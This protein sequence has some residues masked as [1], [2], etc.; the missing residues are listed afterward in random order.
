MDK[1]TLA[2]P[3][4][5]D[6]GLE[7]EVR[8]LR[9][10]VS[11]LKADRLRRADLETDLNG[12]R[13]IYSALLDTTSSAVAVY[14]PVNDGEDFVF[15]DL[16][17][18]GE[19]I[20]R[21]SRD[22][23][24]DRRVTQVFPG[25]KDSGLFDVFQ[26]AWKSGKRQRFPLAAYRDE[27]DRTTWREGWVL[28][29]PAGRLIAVYD[30]VTERTRA[31]EA[32]QNT[33]D[34]YAN[35]LKGLSEAVYRMS[36]PDGRYE[37]FSPAC[38]DV[39]GYSARD[40]LTAPH[41]MTEIVHPDFAGYFQQI[42]LDLLDGTVPPALEYK[43]LDPE[44][45]ERW[46]LQ[47]TKP[48]YDDQGNII[49][50][51]GV[52]RNVT[53]RKQA[54]QALR[55][56]KAFE[57]ALF[58]NSPTP[59]IIV[60]REGCVVR[61]NRAT[62]TSLGRAPRIG[63]KMYVDYAAKHNAHMRAELLACMRSGEIWEFEEL[64]YGNRHL[65]VLIAPFEHGAI[66]TCQDIT[67]RKK[68]EESLR[69]QRSALRKRLKELNLLYSL[70]A[71]AQTPRA[72]VADVLREVVA[73]T[74]L[75]WQYSDDACVR[76][77]LDDTTS[78]SDNFEE[79]IWRLACD[80]SLHGSRLGI[81]EIDYLSKHPEADV[82]PFLNE[83]KDLLYTV[84]SQIAE[85]VGQRRAEDALGESEV[86][87]RHVV[88]NAFDGIN[89]SEYDPVTHSRRLVFCNDRYVEVSGYAREVLFDVPNVS[90]LLEHNHSS[91]EMEYRHTCIVNERPFH[92]IDSWRRPDGK[93]NTYEWTAVSLK[94]GNAYQI[95]GVDRDITER[96]RAEQAL[97]R[98]QDRLREMSVALALA[99]EGERN[100]IAEVLHDQIGQTLAI[101]KMKLS[102]VR[103]TRRGQ[104]LSEPLGE[105]LDYIDDA[106]EFTRSL[107]AQITD[108]ALYELGFEA[109]V[110][111]LLEEAG[112]QHRIRC[113][114]HDDGQQKDLQENV[115]AVLYRAVR[116]LL[117]NVVKHA[118]ARK[119][120]ASIAKE[121]D[122]IRVQIEDNGVGMDLPE[123]YSPGRSKGFGLFSIHE[124][125]SHV[126]GELRIS[127]ASG[128][129]TQVTLRAP[130]KDAPPDK[131]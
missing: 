96:Q 35:L 14:D 120:K 12:C 43:I 10:R 65:S 91:Q 17:A 119:V 18:A 6:P 2:K 90:G 77:V 45:N 82:D 1:T 22:D 100:R 61:F 125:L 80:I 70:A 98:H 60:D 126:G 55:Q 3:N 62:R 32:L 41:L 122:R 31:K 114:F 102:E 94:K 87:F 30:D 109:A 72:T 89:I 117:V 111:N 57:T 99:E 121:T 20:E 59:T 113:S 11:E 118:N 105:V 69:E 86:L 127:S 37:Y 101:S 46:I 83:E 29:T 76:I 13:E 24:L 130:L 38:R 75:A 58:E 49:A 56:S 128:K 84:A 74:P 8:M 81:I 63:D 112:R 25:V 79:T 124:S 39:F 129:G 92:G 107:T 73:L 26:R 27:R 36:L 40:F 131:P 116:E 19:T 21:V 67:E 51:Q 16:N 5:D 15:V 104:K 4:V 23:V 9:A 103:L 28:K 53:E 50:I 66:I 64:P 108:R 33:E 68:T 71:N 34:K 78:Q 93:E 54:E 85:F 48:T 110:E 95:I 115:R 123:V 7:Q 52:C 47:S 97:L 44:G 106:I 88:E 42:W